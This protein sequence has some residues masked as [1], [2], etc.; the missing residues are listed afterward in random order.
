MMSGQLTIHRR[1]RG[2]GGFGKYLDLYLTPYTKI[3]SRGTA[4]PN[5]KGQCFSR[6]IGDYVRVLGGGRD[7]LNRTQKA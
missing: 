5:V 2:V 7:D 1:L 6:K 4:H 3:N